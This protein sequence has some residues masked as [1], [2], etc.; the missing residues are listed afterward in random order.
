[1]N[2]K[3]MMDE[4]EAMASTCIDNLVSIYIECLD[5]C[6]RAHPD[7]SASQVREVASGSVALYFAHLSAP[8]QILCV[9]MM[10]RR[11]ADRQ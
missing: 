3:K 1:M 6:Q 2:R 5:A 4:A 10:I 7:W 8:M 11:L 9:G